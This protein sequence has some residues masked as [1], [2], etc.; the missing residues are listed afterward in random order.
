VSGIDVVTL[1]AAYQPVGK[2]MRFTVEIRTSYLHCSV[3][4]VR[5][6][7]WVPGP[8]W[9]GAE[10]LAPTGTRSQDRAVHSQSPYRL[11]YPGIL[12]LLL[13]LL[14]L[15]PLICLHSQ[16]TVKVPLHLIFRQA[17]SMKYNYHD[18][19]YQHKHSSTV[20]LNAT[21]WVVSNLSSIHLPSPRRTS[22]YELT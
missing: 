5:K 6:A 14:L 19:N 15:S 9:T 17:P 13:L 20:E 11:S 12:L 10:S 21:Q 7:G 22:Y 4:I 3:P 16:Y 1:M 8:V 2:A 18:N